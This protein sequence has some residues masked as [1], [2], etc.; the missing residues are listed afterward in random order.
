MS[1]LSPQYLIQSLS[2]TSD[3]R[4]VLALSGGLDSMVLL[5]LLTA[6]RKLQ[7][8][9]L[10]AVYVHHGISQYA[11]Q[12]GEFCARQCAKRDVA[13]AEHKVTLAGAD[14]LEQKARQARYQLLAEYVVSP[15]H[16]LVTAHHSDDQ[17][18]TL[19]LALKRGAGPA[20][21][22]GIAQRRPFAAGMLCRPL[23]PFSREQLSQLAS[24]QQL[25]WVED[26]SNSD[27]RFERNFVRRQVTPVLLQRWPHFAE[28]AMRSM[29]HLAAQQQLLQH[30]TEQ[31]LQQC[32]DGKMLSLK[33]LVQY[34]A[35]Q[36]DL[37]IRAWL[38]RF[39]LNPETQ[40]LNTLKQQVIAARQD[41]SPQLQLGAYQVRRFAD[42]LY[43]LTAADIS[44]AK[45]ALHWQGEAKLDLP[46]GLGRVSFS[47][48]QE[49]EA[50][51]LSG[52]NAELVFGQL[53][54]R[55]TPAGQKVSKP[56]KQW[57][58]LWQVPPWQRQ[59]I[60]L[61]LVDGQLQVVVGYA[62]SVSVEHATYFVNWQQ[63]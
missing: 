31:A 49:G 44:E 5:Q 53:S 43:L 12:W 9:M 39:E 55:F 22:A 6:A 63:A 14:N 26:D 51:A 34:P 61:L 13:F 20:G 60:P 16:I 36:Q 57:F 15:K 28:S 45:I 35:L 37:V 11:S 59:R 56:L 2:L 50:Y 4:I 62:S 47:T 40:W 3:S 38:G 48:T 24:E 8:F 19:I 23:L 1:D 58:K 52:S 7:P 27:T 21:L 17:L 41:A 10:Q 18:E 29:Q 46:A 33:R 30:Y 32:A 54:L 42:D 25:E